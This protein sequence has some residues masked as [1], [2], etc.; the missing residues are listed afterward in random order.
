MA[1]FRSLLFL[2]LL[3]TL[4][5]TG[6]APEPF[7]C[8]ADKCDELG[9]FP[10]GE[11]YDRYRG[12]KEN[13]RGIPGI[14]PP[15]EE[16]HASYAG[17]DD[18]ERSGLAAWHLYASEG[19]FL[20]EINHAAHGFVNVLELM[21]SRE[22]NTRFE[23]FG[24]LND[25]G[26]RGNT[27]V[28]EFGLVLDE[29]DDPYSSGILGVRLMPNPNF[30]R[31]AWDAI[32][33][34]EGHFAERD[35]KF[36]VDGEKVTGWE[37]EPPYLPS[38]ACT[39][40]HVAPNPLNP[41][42]DINNPQWDEV[43]FAIG[44]QYFREGVF[45]GT[46]LPDD[47]FSKQLLFSQPAGT[48]D[49]SRVAT[50]HIYNPNMIN[51]IANLKS[52]PV[53]LEEAGPGYNPDRV[54]CDIEVPATTGELID[55]IL[56]DDPRTPDGQCVPTLHV[57]KD[58]GDASGPTGALLRVFINVGSCNDQFLAAAGD[59]LHGEAGQTPINRQELHDSCEEYQ[60][61]ETKVVDLLK[62]LSYVEPYN[63]RDAEG[64]ES[65]TLADGRPCLSEDQDELDR[66]AVVFAENCATCHSSVQPDDPNYDVRDDST[67]FNEERNAFFR[68]L[69]AQPDFP[70][71]NTLSDDRR[72]PVTFIGTNIARAFAT[73]ATEGRVWAEYSSEDY[74]R[75]DSV[76]GIVVRIPF[77]D[78]EFALPLDAPKGGRGFYR[79]PSLLDVWTSAPFLHNNGLGPYTA[80]YD[81][82]GRVETYEAAAE[83][84]L[85]P[86][87]RA[88]LDT[89]R[90]TQRFTWLDTGMLFFGLKVKVPIASGWPIDM[91]GNLG[92]ALG[93]GEVDAD[94]LLGIPTPSGIFEN[95]KE[96]LQATDPIQDKGHTFGERL[97]Q[98]DKEAL[99]EYMKA[100]F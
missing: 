33:G 56:T 28:D 24:V 91:F 50:D 4:A 2:A 72:Y 9:V 84:L 8:D 34:A 19:S 85:N 27:R 79:P 71:N 55:A 73:N 35:K 88:G 96:F 93:R 39:T 15:N 29:C 68:D 1:S 7:T 87:L 82:R 69:V 45:L 99:I 62:F 11:Q 25:P 10:R 86:E 23:R 13:V 47:E 42:N 70:A 3:P 54:P 83:E 89:V 81:V 75:L 63:L 37:V 92:A 64:V 60:Q 67:W 12:F 74:K 49:T 5:C 59:Y 98:E 18:D 77:T 26:C 44:N 97:P 94:A 46:Q 43:A 76:D 61:L 51:G 22:R 100:T 65:C 21:D 38:L 53:F 6:D 40:C 36:R 31:S 95:F 30:D 78:N 58:G 32:G 52:R 66:G 20:R 48:S 90:R 16:L 17:M 14:L 41:P 80:A 57:L